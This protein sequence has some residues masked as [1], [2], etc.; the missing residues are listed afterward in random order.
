M[1]RSWIDAAPNLGDQVRRLLADVPV[2]GLD[3][4][5]LGFSGRLLQAESQ[6]VTFMSFDEDVAQGYHDFRRGDETAAVAFLHAQ[7]IVRTCRPFR[8]KTHGTI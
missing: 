2:L 7:S 6:Q 5:L 1:S 3:V 8:W 4:D